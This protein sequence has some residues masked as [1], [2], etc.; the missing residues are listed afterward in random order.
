MFA[1]MQSP[2]K[3]SFTP[4]VIGST[5]LSYL[6]LN[7][8]SESWPNLC[9]LMGFHSSSCMFIMFVTSFSCGSV[10]LYV[11]YHDKGAYVLPQGVKVSLWQIY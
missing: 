10:S 2:P 3:N 4:K 11:N 5:V 1:E 9:H 7:K 8:F 6:V